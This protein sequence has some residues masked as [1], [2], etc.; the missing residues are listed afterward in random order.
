[1]GSGYLLDTNICLYFLNRS[2]TPS[3]YEFVSAILDTQGIRIS[4]VTQIELLGF[5]FPS[6]E[7]KTATESLVNDAMILTLNEAVVLKT[8]AIRRQYR[9]KLPDAIIAATALV[10]GL[11]LVTRNVADFAVV[12]TLRVVNPFQ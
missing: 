5:R 2:L 10:H 1:M 3:A 11:T 6:D 7:E 9:I 12:D 8:I 4:V